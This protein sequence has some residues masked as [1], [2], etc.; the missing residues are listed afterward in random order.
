MFLPSV[1]V[2][3]TLAAQA[4]ADSDGAALYQAWCSKCHGADGRGKAAATAR[5][6][7]PP[8][9]LQECK[10]STAEPE[11]RWIGIVTHGGA[12]LGLS[13]D[14]PAF[15]EAGTP[16]QVRAVVRYARSLCGELGWPPGELNF[17]RPFLVEKAFPEN[18]WVVTAAGRQ[19]AVAYERRFGKRLQLEGEARTAFDSL[20]Q[21]FDGVTA[22]VKYNLWHSLERRAL[23]SL[24]LEVTPPLGR[25][26]NWEIEP[27]L[28]FGAQPGR[29]LF[30]QGEI[31]AS[32]EETEGIAAFS[33]RLGVGREV[34]RVVPM[35]E[36]GWTVPLGGERTLALYPQMW[37][38]LSRLG[39]VAAS[40]GAD[41]P[42]VGPEPRHPRLI[43]FVLWDYGDAGLLRGW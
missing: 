21:P 28:A 3:V 41:L 34:G 23:A 6:A 36:A 26:D 38:Q 31:V 35:L 42:A 24:G 40:L 43:G 11:A 2:L 25:Q 10:A 12:A 20:D 17:P 16:A 29:A 8:A 5:L 14:M 19:Q 32:W 4:P 13:L 1:A 9:D 30:V 27:F 7:V 37:V 15:G 39:H 18:E 22:S 33:Y